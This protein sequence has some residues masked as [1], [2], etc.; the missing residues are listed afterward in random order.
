MLETLDGE[1]QSIKHLVMASPKR[2]S[3][4]TFDVYSDI[5]EKDWQ[6][7]VA[8]LRAGSSLVPTARLAGHT[9]I[10]DRSR[11]ESFGVAQGLL[12]RIEN[13]I[14]SEMETRPDMFSPDTFLNLL[15]YSRMM[16]P[17]FVTDLLGNN[18]DLNWDKIIA[19]SSNLGSSLEEIK[20]NSRS[21]NFTVAFSPD[22]T[23][24]DLEAKSGE[25]F[26]LK[27][28][29]AFTNFGRVAGFASIMARARLVSPDHF[30][31]LPLKKIHWDAMREHLDK[32]RKEEKLPHQFVQHAYHM[33]ILAAQEVQIT[34]DNG[35]VVVPNQPLNFAGD[36][37]ALQMQ[38]RF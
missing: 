12:S 1:R 9:S 22:R 24:P 11:F 16:Q 17:H 4:E 28:V 29:N 32:L 21:S 15:S 3:S 26:S 27:S 25:I 8:A 18:P 34:G 37:I 19:Q 7:I 5:T 20:A 2:P 36:S 10:L 30:S 31:D 33:H 6:G 23:I 35:L 13:H 38:R 14:V